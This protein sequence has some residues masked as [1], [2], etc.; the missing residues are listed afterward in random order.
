MLKDA[1]RAAGLTQTELEARS[2]VPQ[3][4][5]SMRDGG[6][7]APGAEVFLR[8]LGATGC[9]LSV[10]R[11]SDEQLRRERVFSDLLRFTSELPHRWPGDDI[12]FP[13]EVWRM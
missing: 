6:P 3:S 13:V 7:A 10:T 9:Q 8:L 1:R 2:G 4:A 11:F 5:I 12:R